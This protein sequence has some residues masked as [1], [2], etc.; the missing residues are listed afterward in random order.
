MKILYV[1]SIVPDS[2]FTYLYKNT[3]NKPGNS[4][5]KYHQLFCKGL[6]KNLED[7]VTVLS[8]PP[9]KSY[10]K[11]SDED[12]SIKYKYAPIIP[13]IGIKQLIVFFSFLIHTLS[14]IMKNIKEQKIIFCS[15]TRLY[16]TYPVIFLAKL[17][18]IKLGLIVCDIPSKTFY[19]KQEHV[20]FK[21][22]MAVNMNES[23]FSMFDFY[24]P[25]TS[26][27]T[28]LV[29]KKNKPSIVVEGFSDIKMSDVNNELCNKFDKKIIIYAGGLFK[30]YGIEM[31]ID[32]VLRLNR[33]DVELWLYGKGDVFPEKYSGVSDVI[34]FKGVKLNSEVLENELKATLLVNPRFSNEEYTQY[35]FPSKVLEYMSTGTFAILTHLKG[36]PDEYF[37]YCGEI[38]DESVE[39]LS[40]ILNHYLSLPI[41]ELHIKGQQAKDF[42]LNKKNN[43]LQTK[44]I[45][46]FIKTL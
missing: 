46:D 40:K 37:K 27:I 21:L 2:Y 38:S 1:S 41:E 10:L 24:V 45:L 34:K 31:L 13:I 15:A 43:I 9:V 29:N 6:S 5:Q 17:F 20:S 26:Y 11:W 22:R 3:A 18:R 32:S 14:W 7:K 28:P 39:G 42:V 33:K 8:Q 30:K 23:L 25:L 36:I 35:S 16:N 44:K 19:Q 12:A 4:N